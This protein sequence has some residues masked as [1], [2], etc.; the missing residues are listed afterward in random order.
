MTTHELQLTG[1]T[2]A[3]T[4]G[5]GTIGSA[6]VRRLMASGAAQIRIYSRDESKQFDLNRQ[7]GSDD[8]LRFLIGDTRDLPRLRRALEGV[9]YLFHAAAMKHVFAC[10]YNPFEAVKTNVIGTQNVID[11]AIDLDVSRVLFASSDKAVNPT[12]T[13][14]TSKLLAEKLITAAT[15]WRGSHR[16][17]FTTVRFGNVVGSRGSV[18]PL[19]LEQIA[20][21]GPV[22]LTDRRMTRFI[23]SIERAVDLMLSAM[24]MAHGGEVF[25][26]KMPA[27]RIE[28]LASVLRNHVSPRYGHA[29]EDVVI[30]E[31]GMQAGEKTAEELVADEELTRCLETDEMYI[32]LPQASSLVQGA[33]PYEGARRATAASTSSDDVEPMTP[34]EIERL[35]AEW[36]VLSP[37]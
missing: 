16:T 37:A 32:V 7:L 33:G 6:I 1:K 8:R 25:V 15:Y 27:L 10:E 21:G 23:M 34:A 2:I 17:I 22:T 26:L 30:E 19:F 3:V 12:S 18:L 9:D 24:A 14:G 35:L 13:M 20:A 36:K 4:G 5:T 11:A 29:V 28:D 31:V